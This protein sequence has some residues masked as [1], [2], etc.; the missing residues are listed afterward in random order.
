MGTG[1]DLDKEQV[2]NP[3]TDDK[4][5]TRMRS[6]D[7][8][9]GH[10]WAK[11]L[12]ESGDGKDQESSS[13]DMHFS[14]SMK[15]WGQTSR[16]EAMEGRGALMMAQMKRSFGEYFYVMT[17]NT[18]HPP[19]FSRNKGGGIVSNILYPTSFSRDSLGLT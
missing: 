1:T 9:H 16:D 13:E 10:S 14:L 17:G 18:T 3:H 4:Y 2:A 6:F 8:F 12:F 5:F 11:G 19:E 7:V 15:L